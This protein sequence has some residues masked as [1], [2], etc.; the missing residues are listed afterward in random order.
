MVTEVCFHI[1]AMPSLPV[2]IMAAYNAV[3][4]CSGVI[5]MISALGVVGMNVSIRQIA[6]DIHLL[7]PFRHSIGVCLLMPILLAARP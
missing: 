6:D 5:F 4:S 2:P 7:L 1:S 3:T